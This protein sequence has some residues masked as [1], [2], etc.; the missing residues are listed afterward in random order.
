MRERSDKDDP[1]DYAVGVLQDGTRF[2]IDRRAAA[3]LPSRFGLTVRGLGPLKHLD[4]ELEPEQWGDLL[5][6]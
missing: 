1:R 5:Y 2:L 4:L 3:R 6:T